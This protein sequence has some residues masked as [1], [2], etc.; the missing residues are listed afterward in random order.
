MRY[1]RVAAAFGLFFGLGLLTLTA[2]EKVVKLRSAE[3]APKFNNQQLVRLENAAEAGYNANSGYPEQRRPAVE[4]ELT[5]SSTFTVYT[6]T[7]TDSLIQALRDNLAA[8]D[9]EIQLLK[10][11]VKS[12][13]DA[14][15]ALTN[16]VRDVEMKLDKPNTAR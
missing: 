9:K 10:E 16:R 11:S 8:K 6:S 4:T 14:N 5:N 2:T 12:L 7:E 15:D 3:G 1:L 13:S